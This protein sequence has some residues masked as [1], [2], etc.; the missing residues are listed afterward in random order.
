MQNRLQAT[1]QPF[2][3]AAIFTTKRRHQ[4]P[5]T[6]SEDIRN[7]S[8]QILFP[9]DITGCFQRNQHQNND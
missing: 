5:S 9:V 2:R 8:K 1:Y 3:K 7:K 4:P 6:H